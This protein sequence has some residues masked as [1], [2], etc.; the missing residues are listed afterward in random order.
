MDYG[1]VLSAFFWRRFKNKE[2]I[3][4]FDPNEVPDLYEAFYKNTEQFEELYVK[5]EKQKGLRKKTMSAEEVFKSGILKERTDTGRIYLVFIDNV[6]N[7]GPFD[8]EYHTIYQSNLCCEIL[9]PTVA[10]GTTKKKFI[11]VKKEVA[12]D[13]L[14]N[15]P[16]QFVK[17]KKL[18]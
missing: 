5:Y 11:K 6:M 1:V 17:L 8:P 4:F 15:K 3:T 13:F 7:Q 9:L 14:L 2:N 10:M 18:K 12:S 16:E